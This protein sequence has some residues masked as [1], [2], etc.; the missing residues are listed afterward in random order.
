MIG[1]LVC[2]TTWKKVFDNHIVYEN[3][4]CPYNLSRACS[5]L[6]R[7]GVYC[8]RKLNQFSVLKIMNYGQS[9]STT[10]LDHYQALHSDD[11]QYQCVWNSKST[12][13]CLSRV[14]STIF[15]M[16]TAYRWAECSTISLWRCIV[17]FSCQTL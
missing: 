13:G 8:Q 9:P 17:G 5:F 15:T 14:Y 3:V 7:M 2:S 4:D 12:T 6:L 16:Q 11:F 1:S 10:N